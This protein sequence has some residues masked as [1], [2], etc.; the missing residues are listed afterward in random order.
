MVKSDPVFCGTFHPWRVPVRNRAMQPMKPLSAAF[1]FCAIHH[2]NDFGFIYNMSEA[3]I[4]IAVVNHSFPYF[5]KRFSVDTHFKIR[6]L[7]Y[8]FS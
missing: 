6:A 1:F 8:K 7:L 4:T 3:V 2:F 5:G